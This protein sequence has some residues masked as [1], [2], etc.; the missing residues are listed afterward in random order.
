MNI[1]ARLAMDVLM[2]NVVKGQPHGHT[3]YDP[4]GYYAV[5]TVSQRIGHT[6]IEDG[7]R[8]ET[9]YTDDGGLSM[10]VRNI[11]EHIRY[12]VSGAAPHPEPKTGPYVFFWWGAPQRWPAPEYHDKTGEKMGPG[13]YKFPMVTHPGQAANPFFRDAVA[14]SRPRMSINIKNGVADWI[15]D[16]MWRYGL[17]ER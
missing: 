1:P 3:E 8:T 10:R 12:V 14:R 7:W 6:P 15:A 17:R 4:R 5:G 11:S 2:E 16:T 9:D 13:Y